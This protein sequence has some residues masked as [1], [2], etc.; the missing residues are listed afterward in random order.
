MITEKTSRLYLHATNVHQ[1]GGKTLL[2]A[3]LA[4]SPKAIQIIAQLDQRMSVAP[5]LPENLK[6][7]YVKPSILKRLWAEWRL[8]RASGPNDVILCFGNLPPLFKPAGRVL[9]FMQ[10]RYLIDDAPVCKFPLKERVRL[11]VERLWLSSRVANVDKFIVQTPSMQRLLVRLTR[12]TVPVQILP[13]MAN[14][15]NYVRRL[16]KLEDAKTIAIG[17]AYVASGEPHKNHQTLIAAW[18]LLAEEEL[19]P[20]LK[21]TLDKHT[22][23]DLCAW[24]DEQVAQ[25]QL[26]IFNKGNLSYDR[27]MKLYGCVDALIYPS[28][29]E[30]IG[31]PLI[32][33]RQAGLPILAS[34]LDY[35]RDVI[36]PEESFDP[37]SPVS[38]ARAVKRF[39]LKEEPALSLNNAE[40]FLE[41]IIEGT[42]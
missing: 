38:I 1:G 14:P 11:W 34:E 37:M 20:S 23:P 2:T 19:Y 26:K 3:L 9:V 30:S 27:V 7:K 40:D 29:F 12:G 42:K 24:I 41:L 39:I 36:D 33:A 6:I 21:L 5:N 28:S 4:S 16:S 22:F 8:A 31:L 13:F 15:T 25:Y 35:V 18:R 17:F 32:E 10:N